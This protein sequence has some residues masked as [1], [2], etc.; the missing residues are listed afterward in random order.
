MFSILSHY[1]RPWSNHHQTIIYPLSSLNPIIASLMS[2]TGG[3]IYLW[4]IESMVDSDDYW[5]WLN[6][7]LMMGK[8]WRNDGWCWL[9]SGW[10][11]SNDRKMIMFKSSLNRGWMEVDNSEIK[12]V[13]DSSR[14]VYII[15]DHDHQVKS[16]QESS[17]ERPVF[18]IQ[19]R[20]WSVLNPL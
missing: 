6:D 16:E 3:S 12:T 8:G 5:W 14:I 20:A 9:A 10:E 1:E 19:S 18:P 13:H 4:S 17:N 7:V 15:R 2:I 11:W